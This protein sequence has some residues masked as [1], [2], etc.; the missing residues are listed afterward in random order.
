MRM[1]VT[2]EGEVD[3]SLNHAA[4]FAQIGSVVD[5]SLNFH[6]PAGDVPLWCAF[7]DAVVRRRGTQIASIGVTNEANLR[8]VPFAPDGAYPNAL[9]ALVGG[10]LAAA[11][12][13]RATG[14]VAAV[15][16]TA[17]SDTGPDA[18]AF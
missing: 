11:E 9:E 10:V 6:D 5:L 14:A 7:V 12:A 15:G 17:A 2:Y 8:G 1:Y 4:Q 18:A 3:A 16:F 13:K